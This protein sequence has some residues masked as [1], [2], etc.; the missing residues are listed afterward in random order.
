M[1]NDMEIELLKLSPRA[2]NPLKRAGINTV[3]DVLE[4]R[5]GLNQ[6]KGLGTKGVDEILK[7]VMPIVQKGCFA[8]KENGGCQALTV[9]KCS[10]FVGC[11]FYKTPAQ[12]AEELKE[13]ELRNKKRGILS[14][15]EKKERGLV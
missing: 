9:S 5:D 2:Y 8:A 11:P 15:I 7:K 6:I 4:K 1:N 12:Y 13:A 14:P 10:E 3:A